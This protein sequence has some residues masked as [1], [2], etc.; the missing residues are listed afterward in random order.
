MLEGVLVDLD[1]AVDNFLV[2]KQLSD[3]KPI[4]KLMDA[5]AD[6]EIDKGANLFLDS[7][8]M[9]D[10]TIARAFLINSTLKKL[11]FNF[12]VHAK[13]VPTKFFTDYHK[14]IDWLKS[15]KG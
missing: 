5:R 7:K 6:F 3:N 13:S 10:R 9:N 15:I 4:L 14:A 2:V 1:D 11:M 12:F 8:E